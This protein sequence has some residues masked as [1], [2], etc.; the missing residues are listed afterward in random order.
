MDMPIGPTVWRRR[1]VEFAQILAYDFNW[2]FDC[3]FRIHHSENEEPLLRCGK[4]FVLMGMISVPVIL[5]LGVP[6]RHRADDPD[7]AAVASINRRRPSA[8]A[9]TMSTLQLA[10]DLIPL[11]IH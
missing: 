2:Q 4:K 5:I 3:A 10:K 1:R 7:L 9:N 11:C 8:Q 6:F